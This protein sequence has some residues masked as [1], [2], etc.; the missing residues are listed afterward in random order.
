[1]PTCSYCQ[2]PFTDGAL[3]CPSCGKPTAS[4]RSAESPRGSAGQDAMKNLW[5]SSSV[6]TRT[7]GIATLVVFIA[8]FL[9]WYRASALGFTVSVDGLH[10]WG[11]VTFLGMLIAAV[12]VAALLG[13]AVVVRA[14][15]GRSPFLLA[16]GAGVLEVAGAV[17]FWIDA[18]SGSGGLG[19]PSVGLYFALIAGLVTG[20]VAYYAWSQSRPERPARH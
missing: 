20:G 6:T 16:L 14:L 2:S 13:G 5:S 19:G 7:L 15:R 1:M 10:R 11:W 18:S 17:A 3:A 12:A 4:V 8:M 9:P